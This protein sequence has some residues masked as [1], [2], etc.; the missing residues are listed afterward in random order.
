M[1]LLDA[2]DWQAQWIGVPAAAAQSDR[3]F[4]DWSRQIPGPSD[5][6]PP[7]VSTGAEVQAWIQAAKVRATYVLPKSLDGLLWSEERLQELQPAVML[8]RE[9]TLA[10]PVKRATIHWCGLGCYELRAQWQARGRPRARSGRKRLRPPCLLCD[11]RCHRPAPRRHERCRG[12]LG[13]WLV[14]SGRGVR[15]RGEA[16]ELWPAWL[17]LQMEIEYLDG[18]VDRLLSDGTWKCSLAG[19]WV[20]NAVFAGE[21]LRSRREMV[22]WIA[23]SSTIR[24]G[25]PSKSS[26]LTPRLQSQDVPPVRRGANR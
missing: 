10:S 20:K 16:G 12:G 6:A 11:A 15:R 9:F 25:P 7:R 18:R 26:P 3:R 21:A 14:S 5:P 24:A 2:K 22:G 13:R 4:R 23:R 8:R 1:G 17:I 19:P